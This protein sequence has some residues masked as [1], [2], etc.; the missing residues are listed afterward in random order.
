MRDKLHAAV[1]LPS[2][3]RRKKVLPLPG[4]ELRFFGRPFGDVV[5]ARTENYRGEHKKGWKY[6]RNYL[7]SRKSK[8]IT[9]FYK[10]IVTE[11]KT[12]TEEHR[13]SATICSPQFVTVCRG[14]R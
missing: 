12:N 3:L 2:V 4:I 13:Y 5:T 11:L 9:E 7:R 10:K 8:I 1:A 14:W 6:H